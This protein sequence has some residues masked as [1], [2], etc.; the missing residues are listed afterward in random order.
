MSPTGTNMSVL[1]VDMSEEALH[2]LHAVDPSVPVEFVFDEEQPFAIPDPAALK[3]SVRDWLEAGAETSGL[4]YVTAEPELEGEALEEEAPSPPLAPTRQRK[5]TQRG[6]EPATAS[7][8]KPTVATLAG[9]IEQLLQANVGISKQ[10]ESLTVRQQQLEKQRQQ[11]LVPPPLPSHQSVLSQPLSSVLTVSQVGSS[12]VVH[13]LGAPPKTLVPASP[14]L[15]RSPLVQHPELGELEAEKLK[16]GLSS[17]SDSL[18]QAVLA[19]SQALTALVSQIAAQSSDPMVDLGSMG[20]TA[21]TRGA[22]GRAKLQAELAAQRGTFFASVLNA[23]ARRMQP[24]SPADGTPGELMARG[25]CGTKY[26]ERFGGFGKHRELGCLQ[27]QVMTIM[28]FLQTEN[29]PAA[30]DAAALLAVTIDQAALDNSRFELATLLC[31]Q[32]EPPSTVFSHKP[33]NVMSKTRAF[34]PLADQKWVTVALA[35]LKELDVIS[36]KRLELTSQAS[37]AALGSGNSEKPKAK[38]FPKR[39]QKWGGKGNQGN[40]EGEEQ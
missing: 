36:A 30:R 38:P 32:E 14:G 29:L 4:G 12:A 1:V 26:L 23:M 31:L 10:L 3:S 19:Q 25:V 17:S 5:L 20:S 15:L 39:K 9:P 11:P 28:D 7:G 37:A 2:R 16:P 21:G 18:A 35:Y 22:Q 33:A 34:S 27:H 40:A 24:T 8:R 6:R 13:H